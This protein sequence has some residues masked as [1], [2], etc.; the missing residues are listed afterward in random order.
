MCLICK[1]MISSTNFDVHFKACRKKRLELENKK[2]QG[3]L[4]PEEKKVYKKK[5]GCGCGK[6]KRN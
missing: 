5:G 2:I 4:T 3:T 1:K 6:K